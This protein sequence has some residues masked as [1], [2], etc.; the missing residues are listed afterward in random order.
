[1]TAVRI[2]KALF[3]SAFFICAFVQFSA[4]AETV[5]VAHVLD[6][7]SF[8]LSDGREIRLIG[9]NAPE[10]GKDGNPDQPLAREARELLNRLIAGRDIELDYDEEKQDR[11]HRTLAHASL[12]DKRSVEEILLHDGL[13]FMIAQSPNLGRHAH[14]AKAEALARQAKRGVWA[15]P[16]FAPKEATQLRTADTGFRLVQGRVKRV[17]RGKHLVYLDLAENVTL[18]IPNEYWSQFGGNPQRFIGQRV[19]ARGWVTTHENRLRL[20]VSHPSM[21]EMIN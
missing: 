9:V 18:A 15:N 17:G 4:G 6:G 19:L 10:Y 7:D 13:A 14:Y 8:R 5:R 2:K 21:L 11:Y 3:T 1:M 20:R 16:F 12:A